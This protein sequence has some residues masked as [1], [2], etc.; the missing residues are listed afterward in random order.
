MIER[1]HVDNEFANEK[2]KAAVLP[3]IVEPYGR[4]EHV[5]FVEQSVRVLKERARATCAGLP[6][7]RYPKVMM[8]ELMAGITWALNSFTTAI[9]D[10]STI[11]PAAIV[12]GRSKLDMSKERIEFGQF[13]HVYL[14]TKNNLTRR[15]V[16]A[17]SMRSAQSGRIGV[18]AAS[19]RRSVPEHSAFLLTYSIPGLVFCCEGTSLLRCAKHSWQCRC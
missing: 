12:E 18:L 17:V 3:A 2:V 14:D 6:Y 10:T 1:W 8:N 5:G 11:S 15:S 7:K 16:P 4:N 9:S 13:A 19:W